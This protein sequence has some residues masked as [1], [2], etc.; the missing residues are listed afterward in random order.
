MYLRN[1]ST[2]KLLARS[3][4]RARTP[5]R[6]LLGW[7]T[8]SAVGIGEGLLFERC[9]AIHTLGMRTPIDVIFLDRNNRVK[10]VNANV[11]P[12]RQHVGCS[13]AV[14][15]LEMGPGF[16]GANDLL[17]GDRLLLEAAVDK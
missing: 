16:L 14:K 13:S 7:L 6:R 5:W 17:I 8:R 15:V 11:V 1:A 9:S 2:G 12:G 10:Q 3:V 4:R